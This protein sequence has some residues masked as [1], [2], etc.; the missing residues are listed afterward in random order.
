MSCAIKRI[1]T[2]NTAFIYGPITIYNDMNVNISENCLY[3]W[4]GDGVCWT[5]WVTYADY[6]RIGKNIETDMYWRVLIMDSLKAVL[7]NDE[8]TTC[9][10]VTLDT[11]N[12]F[13]QDFCGVE[14]LFNPYANLDCALLLQQQMADS[15]ICM[16][17]IPIYYFKVDPQAETADYTF[18]EYLIH[19]VTSVKQIKMMIP[20]GQMPS[21]KPIFADEDFNWEVDWEVELGKTQFARAFGDNAFPSQRDIIYVPLM[22]RLWEVNSAWD[23]KQEAFMWRSTTWNLGLVKY[24]EKPNVQEGN[25]EDLIQSFVDN[26]M[27]ETFGKYEDLEQE[28]K[29][30]TTQATDLGHL[31]N[32]LYN[33]TMQDAI[34]KEFSPSIRIVDKN[35]HQRS[36]IISHNSYQFNTGG[37]V[38]YQRKPCTDCGAVSI[39][40]SDKIAEEP[41]L[42][43]FEMGNVKV[44]M[45]Y[46]EEKEC[47][48]IQ[49]GELKGTLYYEYMWHDVKQY[50][51]DFLILI[52][53]NKANFTVDLNIY[54]Y[55]HRTDVPEDKLK[56]HMWY[57]DLEHPVCSLTGI[58]NTEYSTLQP[59]EMVLGGCEGIEIGG[60]KVFNSPI[61][62]PELQ[63]EALKHTTNNPKCVVNDCV[64]PWAD[65][66]GFASK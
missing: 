35:I 41:N 33:I 30:G 32:N 11:T 26:T 66:L 43:L 51:T 23:E 52:R 42:T 25:F 9:Y 55:V 54:P 3:S 15:I 31:P 24:N 45:H 62:L 48:V 63:K 40:I 59:V 18:K 20:D 17:G 61:D 44:E 22:K 19:N 58:Y 49:F 21:S 1:I 2:L 56:P 7:I 64:K 12:P 29:S 10:S 53:W 39:I 50:S 65:I 38:V 4:S 46:D 14:T 5:N 36:T 6:H 37:V 47:G 34:R 16:F 27:F 57:F 13:L 60:V 28:R 8:P